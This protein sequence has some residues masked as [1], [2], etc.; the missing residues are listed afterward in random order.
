MNWIEV[1]ELNALLVWT[2]SKWFNWIE[3]NELLVWLSY[4][5][6][7]FD[8]HNEVWDGLDYAVTEMVQAAADLRK[9]TRDHGVC[10]ANAAADVDS[11]YA[12][13]ATM[14]RARGKMDEVAEKLDNV[15]NSFISVLVVES[16]PHE[17]Q[18]E[19][20]SSNLDGPGWV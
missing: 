4:C 10:V 14:T 2:E 20:I 12:H 18:E 5:Y 3:M 1:I 16:P 6:M 15:A 19:Y 17:M 7:Q 11:R 9:V 13:M 8:R